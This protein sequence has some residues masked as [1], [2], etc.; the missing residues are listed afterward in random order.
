MS[1]IAV[2]VMTYN[3]PDTIEDVLK[4]SVDDYK[5]LGIDIYYYDT[6]ENEDTRNIIKDWQHRGYDNLY[7]VDYAPKELAVPKM[8]QVIEG[9]GLQKEYDYIWPIKDRSW[10][11]RAT[12]EQI[13]EA[14]E[15]GYD[16]IF[17]GVGGEIGQNTEYSRAELFY[18]DWGWLATSIDVTIFKRDSMIATYYRMVG[19][20][21]YERDRI[22]GWYHYSTLLYMFY[23]KNNPLVYVICNEEAKI[24]NSQLS[25]SGWEERIFEIWKDSWIEINESLP[26]VYD[27]YKA[28]ITKKGASLPWILGNVL[29]LMELH[30][31]G[32]LTSENCGEVLQN[33]ER[34]SNISPSVVQRIACGNYDPYHETSAISIRSYAGTIL[35]KLI[36]IIKTGNVSKEQIPIEEV[37]LCIR[38]EIIQ[39]ARFQSEK[40]YL[41]LGTVDDIIDYARK[42]EAK[43]EEIG[44]LLQALLV[45]LFLAE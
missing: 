30:E 23:W 3:H 12:L 28:Y 36:S 1:R 18:R 20:Q 40:K 2:C 21:I 44:R 33:W 8:F 6:S 26:D 39:N 34:V 22:C 45:I 25:K 7:C 9:K 38:Q 31:K 19:E 4:E 15:R 5:E 11:P 42:E 16:A 17:L 41:I 29:R 13:M 10:C 37:S 32:I 24:N 14:V 27:E 43:T 35:L